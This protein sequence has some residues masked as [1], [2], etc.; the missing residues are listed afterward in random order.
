M[1]ELVAKG[2]LEATQQT[3][4]FLESLLR[5]SAD[6]IVIT[7]VAQNILVVNDAFCKFIGQP[8]RNV[9]ETS[10][11]TWLGR[12]DADAS[13]RWSELEETVHLKGT[14]QN[15]EFQTTTNKGRR[16]YSVN[17]SLVEQVAGEDR[18]VII[19]IWRDV[20]ERRR[21]E[22]DLAQAKEA[23]E[24]ANVAKSLFLG[25]MS[26]EIRT[27][28]TSILGYADLLMSHEWP[29]SERREHL[30]VI[31]R[32]GNNLLTIIN[33]ILDLSKI[34]A[35][36]I[37]LER[38]DCS[39]SE[40]VEEVRSL[41][42]VHANEKNLGL[43][44]T[45]SYPLP[46]TIRTDPVR[47]RQILVNLVG[48]AIK[49]TE[50]GGVKVRVRYADQQMQFEITDTGIGMSEEEISRLFQPFTQADMSHTRRFGGTGLG[51][52]IS[53]K[54]A[55][56]LGGLVEVRSE[57]GVGSTF[58]LTIHPGP[59][60]DVEMES[61]TKVLPKTEEPVKR[62]KFHGRIL[63]AEDVPEV[64]RFV[65][66]NLQ[67]AGLGVELAG[68][69]EVAIEKALAS[70]AE[71]K[72]YD[73]ILMDIQMPEVSGFEA[74]RRLRQEGWS[75]PIIALTAHAMTGDKERCLAAGCDDYISKP[76]TDEALFGTIGRYLGEGT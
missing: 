29:P 21:A 14:C 26:H 17:A 15:A 20:T 34:E 58:T 62:R 63:F 27:P 70:K 1:T 19:S 42:Q 23:A 41:L 60:E 7:D 24:A 53:Q 16:H 66:M 75:G 68:N 56:L 13:Q 59:L 67:R 5:A 4:K 49:F 73:L 11:F 69:G 47:L 10:L 33:D 2:G 72:P 55:K 31:Q 32:Q 74:T 48:N 76:M 36:Q 39:P 46:K 35:E 64:Q 65:Q 43:D 22:A 38:I 51:L 61:P 50:Q 28:M 52:H 57:P 45:Y 6:G 3:V 12:F 25:N 9:V 18:G 44:T 8:W 30:Q 40:V 71:G 54:L 37:E